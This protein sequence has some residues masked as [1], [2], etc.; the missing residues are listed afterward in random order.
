[1]CFYFTAHK[2]KAMSTDYDRW[3]GRLFAELNP[4]QSEMK[5]T[6]ELPRPI[7]GMQG[8]RITVWSNFDLMCQKMNRSP[9]QVARFISSELCTTFSLTEKN[10]MKIRY[11]LKSDRACVMLSKFINECV[12]CTQCGGYS[13]KMEKDPVLRCQS[14]HCTKCLH[15]RNLI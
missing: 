7:V 8:G 12:K 2:T 1:M 13:T 15:K 9:D 5:T 6:I 10:A 11:K 14:I 4:I 3:V